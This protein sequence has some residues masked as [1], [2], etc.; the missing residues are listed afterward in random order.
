ML[1]RRIFF[2]AHCEI[3]VV[4]QAA[5]KFLYGEMIELSLGGCRIKAK[6]LTPGMRLELT[7]H[8][9]HLDRASIIPLAYEVRWTVEGEDCLVGLQFSAGVDA[10]FRGWLADRLQSALPGQ[11]LM[12][13]QRH[14]VRFRCALE[15]VIRTE[16]QGRPRNCTILELSVA[17]VRVSSEGELVPGES[18]FLQLVGYPE[19]EPLDVI[20][21]RSEGDSG[22]I[23]SGL[24]FLEPTEEQL[25][26]LTGIVSSLFENS[27][28]RAGL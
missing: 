23:A 28:M 9:T 24:K 8:R 11:E 6:E 2:R 15:G 10:F 22:A 16:S 4:I 13:E 17:G 21:L 27:S 26:T 19:L 7:P 20:V 3:P 14:M 5:G 1:N 12:L 18:F 25:K